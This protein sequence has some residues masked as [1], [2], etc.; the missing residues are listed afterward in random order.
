M[1]DR[2]NTIHGMYNASNPS[3]PLHHIPYCVRVSCAKGA[4]TVTGPQSA[5]VKEDGPGKRAHGQAVVQRPLFTCPAHV[6]RPE[7][8]GL[9]TGVTR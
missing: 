9:N 5:A 2:D 4:G 6:K 1:Q 7:L 8:D 3:K